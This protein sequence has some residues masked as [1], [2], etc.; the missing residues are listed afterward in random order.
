MIDFKKSV[1]A[2]LMFTLAGAAS[3]QAEAVLIGE[4]AVSFRADRDVVNVDFDDRFTGIRICVNRRA[5]RFEDL[6]VVFGNG[7]RQDLQ[8]RNVIRA[9]G[10]TRDIDIRG[11][12]RFIDQVILNYRTVGAYGNAAAGGPQA[13][14]EVF[15]IN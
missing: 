13:I 4:K 2:A 6:D 14:V 8:I 3:A 7:A 10:C 9:G 12:A 5:V 1:I 15:G 11:E